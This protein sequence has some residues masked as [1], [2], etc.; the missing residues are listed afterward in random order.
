MKKEIKGEFKI[1]LYFILKA[2][3]VFFFIILIYRSTL[4]WLYERFIAV[5]SYYSHGFLVPFIS[6][7]LI[8]GKNKELYPLPHT[9]SL[10]GLFLIIISLL[11][12]F[13]SIAADIFFLSGFSLIVLL[14]G[15]ISFLYGQVFVRKIW[16]PLFF[17][18][19]MIPLPLVAIN[20]ISF[21]M[22]MMVTKI[23]VGILKYGVHIPVHHDGFQIFFPQSSM[24]V[25]NPCSGLRSLISYLALGAI[26]AYLLKASFL[27]KLV[28]FLLAIPVA[29]VSN[30]IRVFLLSLGVYIYGSGFTKGFFHDFSGFFVFVIGMGILWK[31]RSVLKCQD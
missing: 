8:W 6:A 15:V 20:A 16:F 27:R 30:F 7:F 23:T 13:M 21:P 26:F 18:I 25:E 4:V 1:P 17:L 2:M 28:L 14:F 19:F 29:L 9:G 10:W 22:K 5:D 11:I 24:V 12:H 3:I 31:A